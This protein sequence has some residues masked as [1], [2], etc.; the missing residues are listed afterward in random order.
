MSLS[1]FIAAG[2][3]VAFF[4]LTMSEIQPQ[5]PLSNF[6]KGQCRLSQITPSTPLQLYQLRQKRVTLLSKVALESLTHSSTAALLIESSEIAI[7][8]AAVTWKLPPSK[9]KVFF[10]SLDCPLQ[11]LTVSGSWVTCSQ[12]CTYTIFFNLL[13]DS[14]TLCG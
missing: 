14:G 10:F 9:P 8:M 3:S 4:H 5:C 1:V 11:I 13:R 2:M 12:D 6:L 7:M